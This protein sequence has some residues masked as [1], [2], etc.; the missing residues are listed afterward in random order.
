M[1]VLRQP[2]LSDLIDNA[3]NS[4]KF[5]WMDSKPAPYLIWINWRMTFNP[6]Y[7]SVM[8]RLDRG[9]Q[10]FW[11]FSMSRR[12]AKPEN[13]WVS[14]IISDSFDA[15][16]AVHSLTGVCPHFDARRNDS[17]VKALL[18]HYTRLESFRDCFTCCDRNTNTNAL[19]EVSCWI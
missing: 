15:Y 19:N 17:Y 18:L 6:Y 3:D 14:V 4:Q 8:P 13:D 16:Q 2:F 9:I 12:P 5:I 10:A 7:S 11:I 1:L